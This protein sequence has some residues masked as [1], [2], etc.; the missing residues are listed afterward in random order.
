MKIDEKALGFSGSDCV[1]HPGVLHSLL[2]GPREQ[3]LFLLPYWAVHPA[4]NARRILSPIL[5]STCSL[6]LLGRKKKYNVLDC[7]ISALLYFY[8]KTIYG[9]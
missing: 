3:A 8:Y 6:Q 4:V 7:T 2:P 9:H 1:L 5:I